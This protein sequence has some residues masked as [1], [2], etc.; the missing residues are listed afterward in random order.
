MG[1]WGT[2]QSRS[3]REGGYALRAYREAKNDIVRAQVDARRAEGEARRAAAWARFK[4][5]G[6]CADFVESRREDDGQS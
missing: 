4:V 2:V 5:S 3:I 1:A 6:S